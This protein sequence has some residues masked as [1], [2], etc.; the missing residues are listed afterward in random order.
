[1]IPLKG[2]RITGAIALN[3]A[4][5]TR[6]LGHRIERRSA[7][8]WIADEG[9]V[10]ALLEARLGAITLSKGSDPAPDPQAIRDFMLAKVLSLFQ[11][12][13]STTFKADLQ[14]RVGGGLYRTLFEPIGTTISPPSTTG[15]SGEI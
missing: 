8:R 13:K 1:M 5:V 7:L 6:W 10:E 9:R 2:A 14:K 15:G 12:K 11:F 4:E 3:D